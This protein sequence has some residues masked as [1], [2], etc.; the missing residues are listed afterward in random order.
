[1]SEDFNPN[2]YRM[3]LM[4]GPFTFILTSRGCPAGCKYCIKHVSYQYSV[5]L[6]SP[7]RI[8]K[9]LWLLHDLGIHNIH[10]YADLF[11][12]NREQVM[13]AYESVVRSG[14]E[15]HCWMGFTNQDGLEFDMERLILPLSSDGSRIDML[16]ALLDIHLHQDV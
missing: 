13:E 8:M 5:R 14:K 10:M 16:I 9:E 12:V 15:H 7:E 11:T 2:E 6:H 4:K 1:M 3:P